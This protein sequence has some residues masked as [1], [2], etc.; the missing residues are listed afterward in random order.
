MAPLKV[1]CVKH[2]FDRHDQPLLCID[3]L[4]GE[5]AEM[6]P[7][8]ARALAAALLD[9]AADCEAAPRL[10]GRILPTRREYSLGER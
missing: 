10:K 4:P 7:S 8:A 6:S 2:T 1:L 5:G 3:N 9:A